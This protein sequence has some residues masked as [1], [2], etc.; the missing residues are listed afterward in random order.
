MFSLLKKVKVKKPQALKKE[1]IL[2][3]LKESESEIPPNL[4]GHFLADSVLCHLLNKFFD[5]RHPL[6]NGF[7]ANLLVNIALI[8]CL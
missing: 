3:F 5:R 1:K 7:S 4:P 6:C 2:S 8:L